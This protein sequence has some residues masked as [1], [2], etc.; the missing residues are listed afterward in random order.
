MMIQSQKVNFQ[1]KTSIRSCF[2]ERMI[3]YTVPWAR[4]PARDLESWIMSQ[5]KIIMMRLNSINFLFENWTS[6]KFEGCQNW[7]NAHCSAWAYV[8]PKTWQH[9]ASF[10]NTWQL[11]ATFGNFCQLLAA[12]G[13]F[14]QLMAIFCSFWQLMA[15]YGNF[16]HLIAT[17]GNLWQLVATYGNF[18]QHLA[19][20]ANLW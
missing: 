13:S 1:K 10:G 3:N 18:C 11:L 16:W 7:T 17:F 5:N 4:E 6:T 19:A 9:L 15:T 20:F 2:F 8:K 14:W 12:F